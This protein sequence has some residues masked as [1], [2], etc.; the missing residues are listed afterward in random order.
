MATSSNAFTSTRAPVFDGTCNFDV[1]KRDVQLWAALSELD[2]A[3]QGAAMLG[4]LSGAAKDYCSTMDLTTQV[5][6]AQ[7]VDKVLKHLEEGFS[8]TAEMRL[9]NN[10]ADWLDFARTPE[11]TTAD[12]VVGYKTR[13]SKLSEIKLPKEIKGHLLLRQGGFDRQTRGLVVASASGS[14]KMDDIISSL[15]G[16]YGDSVEMPLPI[17]T[18][19]SY[20]QT[21]S[22]SRKKKGKFCDHCHRKGHNKFECWAHMRAT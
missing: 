4:G 22:R 17:N 7:G 10:I 20:L 18:T 15:K 3:K 14:F 8:S 16:L 1:Y 2:P 9:H 13:I 5:L 21:I 11:M 6:N 12:F 19:S